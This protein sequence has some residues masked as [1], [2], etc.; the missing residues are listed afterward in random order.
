MLERAAD[1][2]EKALALGPSDLAASKLKEF[3]E[4]DREEVLNQFMTLPGIGPAKASALYDAG[5]TSVETLRGASM[6]AL[7][8]VKGIN[9]RLAKRMLKEMGR[10]S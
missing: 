10:E 2:Y 5:F 4:C 3:R 9:E 6:D 7:C 1:S 8:K